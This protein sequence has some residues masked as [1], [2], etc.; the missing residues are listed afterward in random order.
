[1]SVAVVTEIGLLLFP[2]LTQLDITGPFEVFARLPKA[3]VHLIWKSTEPVTSDRGLSLTPTASYADCP[4]LDVIVVPGGFGVQEL[5]VDEKTLD[6]LRH[7]ASMAQWITAVCT[8]SLVLGA[9]GL[10]NGYRATSPWAYT[11]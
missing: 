9:A 3:H 2:N 11:E 1:G 10:L 4:D 6:F 8:G 5:L 7:Q